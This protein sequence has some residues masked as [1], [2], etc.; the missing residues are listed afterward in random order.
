MNSD[1]GSNQSKRTGEQDRTNPERFFH[2][3]NNGWFVYTREGIKGPFIDKSRA[4]SFLEQFLGDIK[5]DIDPSNSW[6]L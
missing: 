2:I 6:R 5:G 1:N 4:G 3:M